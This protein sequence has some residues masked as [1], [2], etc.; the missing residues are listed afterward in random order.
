MKKSLI[1][2]AA[3][4]TVGAAQAQSNVT[5]YGVFDTGINEL[6]SKGT[7]AT[8]TTQVTA[9]ALQ[10][11]GEAASNRLGFRGTEDLGGGLKANFVLESS[12]AGNT[13]MTFG[14][15]GAWAGLQGGF[16]ELRVGFQ[17]TGARDVWLGLDQLAAAN[18]AGNLAH[19]TAFGVAGTSAHTAF[20]TGV[21]YIT[22]RVN[23]LQ[24]SVAMSR[25]NRE[26]TGAVT[27]KSAQ[28][29]SM[30]G[31]YVAGK[32]SAG[33]SYSDADTVTTAAAVNATAKTTTGGA[34]Y[35]FGVARVA[36]IYTKLDQSDAA[37]AASLQNIDRTSHSFSASA[38]ISAK[39]V[40][41]AGYGFG[42]YQI[43]GDSAFKADI[44]GMQV[45]VNHNLSKRTMAYAIY[46]EQTRER[47]AGASKLKDQEYSVGI[48]H[49]F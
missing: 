5:I 26:E 27:T 9:E 44:K 40:L 41:R 19:S 14:G 8:A 36:Y 43:G 18:V 30:G 12:I 15:R 33:I 7:G 45:A 37:N 29:Y 28:G 25:N 49:S 13:A 31:S 34:M 21:Q 24:G 47:A 16:G 20:N 11:S 22:R 23:G 1:A 42:K 38:P 46:G 48:R 39:T 10:T 6:K 4:A 2:L 17:N 32:F 35:D 3:L